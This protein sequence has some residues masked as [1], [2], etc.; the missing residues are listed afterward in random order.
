M[1]LLLSPD[2]GDTA[3]ALPLVRFKT[4]LLLHEE[5]KASTSPDEVEVD[6]LAVLGE[7]G[8]D[9]ALR[10]VEGQAARV[11]I[12][13]VP[14]ARVPG[15]RVCFVGK[16]CVLDCT[17]SLCKRTAVCVCLTR[18]ATELQKCSLE[19]KVLEENLLPT[20]LIF[21]LKPVV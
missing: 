20:A 5:E 16:C 13:R 10:E 12:G 3:S 21:A 9:V 2:G 4:L 11:D 1:R 18:P 14:E 6:D 7:D 15:G 17:L 8:E 19:D